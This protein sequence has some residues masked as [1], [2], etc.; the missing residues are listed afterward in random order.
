[1]VAAIAGAALALVTL[2]AWLFS[3]WQSSAVAASASRLRIFPV[4]QGT[5]VRDAAVNGRVVAAVSPTLYAPA[6]ATVSLKVNAGDT[7]KAGQVLAKLE[8][9]DLQRAMRR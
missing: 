2:S 1:R 9:P 8:S 4:P 6:G 5:L 7:V 3:G